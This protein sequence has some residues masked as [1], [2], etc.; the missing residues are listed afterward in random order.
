M[1][2]L[3]ST[4]FTKANEEHKGEAGLPKS[5]LWNFIKEVLTQNQVLKQGEV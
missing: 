1:H 4:D 2:P 5:T 3:S